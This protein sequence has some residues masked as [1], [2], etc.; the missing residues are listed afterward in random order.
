MLEKLFP[1]NEGTVDRAIRVVLGLGL[2]SLAV[3]GPQT[4]LGLLGIIPL[5]TGLIGSCQLYRLVGLSTCPAKQ[6]TD[7]GYH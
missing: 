1:R 5:A 2:L 4:W 3:V 6:A 7:P